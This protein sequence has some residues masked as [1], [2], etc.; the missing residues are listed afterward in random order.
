MKAV[1][2]WCNGKGEQEMDLRTIAM[3]MFLV[4]WATLGGLLSGITMGLFFL[5]YR[6]GHRKGVLPPQGDRPLAALLNELPKFAVL[7]DRFSRGLR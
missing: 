2:G 6:D 1:A 7:T 4:A 3:A 5:V